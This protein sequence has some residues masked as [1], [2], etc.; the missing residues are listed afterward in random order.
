MVKT[1]RRIEYVLLSPINCNQETQTVTFSFMPSVLRKQ[2]SNATKR[3]YDLNLED[4]GNEIP[5]ES[6][7]SRSK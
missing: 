6:Y 7:K 1:I 2:Q 3:L 5:N 4:F